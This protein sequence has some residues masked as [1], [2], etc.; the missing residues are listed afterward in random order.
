MNRFVEQVT[1]FHK[2]FGHRVGKDKSEIERLLSYR[3]DPRFKSVEVE[4]LL[5]LRCRLIGEEYNEL[6]E[7]VF[8]LV[9]AFRQGFEEEKIKKAK[10]N[11]LDALGDI[12]V[13][14][15]GTAVALGFDIETAME[16]IYESNMSKLG[17]DGKPI[18]R[19]DG[20]ILKGPN[21]APPKLSDLV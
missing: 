13:V 1:E 9:L 21:Y 10:Q 6:R 3:D 18:Y 15:I 11:I 17:S 7:G 5:S 4:Q 12:L 2:V 19:E 8:D 16:R 20:K 14:T